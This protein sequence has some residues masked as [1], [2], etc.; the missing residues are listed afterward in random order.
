MGCMFSLFKGCSQLWDPGVPSRSRCPLQ[1]PSWLEWVP[2]PAN[3]SWPKAPQHLI[4]S[5]WLWWWEIQ[6]SENSCSPWHDSWKWRVIFWNTKVPLQDVGQITESWD[7]WWSTSCMHISMSWKSL[8][9]CYFSSAPKDRIH[10]R[11]SKEFF[12]FENLWSYC[13]QR[14]AAVFVPWKTQIHCLFI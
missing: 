1:S 3:K 9:T 2:L 13:F 6:T 4:T 10:P 14:A 7:G 12:S 5:P 8:R 11:E